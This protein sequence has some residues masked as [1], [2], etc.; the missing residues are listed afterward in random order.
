MADRRFTVTDPEYF[1][2]SDTIIEV[3]Y[4]HQA[5]LTG[6]TEDQ[7]IKEVQYAYGPEVN[8]TAED[9]RSIIKDDLVEGKLVRLW[10]ATGPLAYGKLYKIL[11][12]GFSSDP[13]LATPLS[14]ISPSTPQPRLINH[15]VTAAY[16]QRIAQEF[17][18]E[19]IEEV[20]D[21]IVS[22]VGDGLLVANSQL[23]L[24]PS[25]WFNLP[26][27][28]DSYRSGRSNNTINRST[29]NDGRS[30]RQRSV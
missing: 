26:T 25:R 12:A 5:K 17:Y 28:S 18:F 14:A 6:L 3:L 9:I 2:I 29:G 30:G 13:Y 7:I 10:S 27:I 24:L 16:K 8:L 11:L 20:L 4:T 23:Y 21:D 1:D 15:L 19:G 22:M